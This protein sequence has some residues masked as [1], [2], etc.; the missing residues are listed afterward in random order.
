MTMAG[1][2]I[3]DKKGCVWLE[4][5]SDW[6]CCCIAFI[7]CWSALIKVNKYWTF[8]CC[9]IWS[10]FARNVGLFNI[11]VEFRGVNGWL[12][13]LKAWTLSGY[14]CWC[15][16]GIWLAWLTLTFW[17]RL[18]WLVC[19]CWDDCDWLN[20]P[21]FRFRVTLGRFWV[22]SCG[23]S[24]V[25]FNWPVLAFW[26]LLGEF[27]WGWKVTFNWF[28]DLWLSGGIPTFGSRSC[29]GFE[30]WLGWGDGSG[31]WTLAGIEGRC[32]GF[33]FELEQR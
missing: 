17:E 1:P 18:G 2:D 33:G 14:N 19:D 10:L 29:C 25:W 22:D 23:W 8:G 7:C 11:G 28:A 26:V 27:C 5:N 24:E 6:C 9:R 21:L 20:W 12:S 32:L 30:D 15:C 13:A 16:D 4:F 3:C 31:A